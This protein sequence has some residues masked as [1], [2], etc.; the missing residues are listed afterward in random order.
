MKFNFKKK[1]YIYIGRF[2][3]FHLGHLSLIKKVLK[4]NDQVALLVMDSYRVNKKNP[5]KF[6]T[7]KQKI[8][9]ILKKNLKYLFNN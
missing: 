4:K 6:E 3:P 1:T 8:E 7:V 2:Q 9:E 5:F